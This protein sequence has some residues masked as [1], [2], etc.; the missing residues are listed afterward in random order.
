MTVYLSQLTVNTV[1]ELRELVQVG[2][3]VNLIHSVV[4]VLPIKSLDEQKKKTKKKRDWVYRSLQMQGR[5]TL[6]CTLGNLKAF[7]LSQP[8]QKDHTTQVAF[9][10]LNFQSFLFQSSCPQ[11]CQ[12]F[13]SML[14]TVCCLMYVR[15]TGD[16]V[17]S[18]HANKSLVR[19]TVFTL[20]TFRNVIILVTII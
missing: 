12:Q 5:G 13:R 2:E 1:N 6:S 16:C 18:D 3:F 14:L 20:F 4:R 19:L 17:Q 10:E 7:H 8:R 11:F 9:T 15:M